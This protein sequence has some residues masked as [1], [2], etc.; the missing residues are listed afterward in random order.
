M[1][2]HNWGYANAYVMAHQLK[3]EDCKKR[4]AEILFHA[5]ESLQS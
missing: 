3:C 1:N 5:W 2:P 4:Y